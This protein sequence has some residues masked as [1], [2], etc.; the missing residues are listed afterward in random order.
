MQ[1]AEIGRLS[2]EPKETLFN[3]TKRFDKVKSVR[4]CGGGHGL[5]LVATV[6]ALPWLHSSTKTPILTIIPSNCRIFDLA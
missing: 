6:T 2:I 4:N 3:K 1:A 5:L